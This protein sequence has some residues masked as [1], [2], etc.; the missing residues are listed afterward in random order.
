MVRDVLP[1]CQRGNCAE[2][3]TLVVSSRVVGKVA[4]NT[5]MFQ[6]GDVQRRS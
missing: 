6:L 3:E 1:L 4:V 2:G 5:L